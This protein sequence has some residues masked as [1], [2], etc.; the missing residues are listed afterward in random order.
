MKGRTFN[1]SL[2]VPWLS[3]DM[4]IFAFHVICQ[5][6]IPAH[7]DAAVYEKVRKTHSDQSQLRVGKHLYAGNTSHCVANKIQSCHRKKIETQ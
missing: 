4:W 7:S 6:L 5:E 3:I 1:F 2:S